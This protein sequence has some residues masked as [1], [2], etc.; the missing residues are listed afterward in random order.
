MQFSNILLTLASASI[1]AAVPAAEPKTVTV[2]PV[3]QSISTVPGVPSV[4]VASGNRTTT[5]TPTAT[6]V[7]PETWSTESVINSKTVTLTCTKT[8][9]QAHDLTTTVDLPGA[10]TYSNTVTISTAEGAAN[11]LERSVFGVLAAAAAQ[12]L[13]I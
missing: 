6:T 13:L 4:S 12:Y 10:T 11:V 8:V 1:A 3:F 7:L 2:T 5:V 9:C